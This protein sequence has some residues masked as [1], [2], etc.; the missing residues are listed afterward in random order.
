[1]N[2]SRAVAISIACIAAA[3]VDRASGQAPLPPL[4][5]LVEVS[6]VKVNIEPDGPPRIVVDPGRFTATRVLLFDLVRYAWGFTS[7]TSQSQVV[8][9]PSWMRTTRFDIIATT[10]GLPSLAML[11]T[12]LQDRFKL[13][14]HVESR[15]GA[16][17]ALVLDRADRRLGP[18][19]HVSTSQCVG[20]GG[21]APPT[22]AAAGTLCGV[23]GQPGS[24]TAEGASMAQLARAL[25][26][27]P[28][29]GRPVIDRTALEG[30]Y[31]WTLQW[32]Q[33]FSAT[34]AAG[35]AAT[36]NPDSSGV[37]L[38]TALREQLGLRLAADRGPIDFLVIDRAEFPTPD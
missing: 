6:S 2:T 10:K 8:G 14:A 36:D 26:G 25:G 31:D 32:T 5:E 17:Y 4:A 21:T 20:A 7:L 15:D 28:A 22:S 23:R 13:M 1:M 33:A 37:S 16:V 30:V 3:L 9:G 38:F 19:I 11:K 12:L 34:P 27:F 18:A 29:V 24:Y 35:A